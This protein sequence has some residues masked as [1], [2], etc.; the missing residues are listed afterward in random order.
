MFDCAHV[1]DAR[2]NTSR[3]SHVGCWCFFVF[4]VVF[5]LF[6]FFFFVF[7]FVFFFFCVFFLDT[8]LR[9]LFPNSQRANL[10]AKHGGKLTPVT[11]ESFL[12]WK[13]KQVA[14]KVCRVEFDST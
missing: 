9:S 14:A 4:F 12:A 5:F 10:A 8:I 2:S 3:A 1:A 11:L 13:Q 7:F 6:F